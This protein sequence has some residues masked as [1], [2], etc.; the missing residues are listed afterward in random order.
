MN[1]VVKGSVILA[2]LIAVLSLVIALT[3]MHENPMVSG[4]VFLVVAIGLNVWLV[5]WVL[6]RTA[7]QAGWGRQVL[8]AAIF[9]AIA[10]VLIFLFSW[11]MLTVL[12]PDYLGESVQAT[13][14][15][16][17][18]TG[19][20][21]EALR[22]QVAKLEAATPISQ[23]FQGLIGTFFTSLVAGAI[24]AIFKRRK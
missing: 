16:L 14:A 22:A 8:H 9:G 17:E 12:F 20:P 5:F 7:A 1:D 18:G 21:E 19:M 10:G 23:A 15:M 13:I 2:G 6:K 11:V 4:L 24:I 3:G